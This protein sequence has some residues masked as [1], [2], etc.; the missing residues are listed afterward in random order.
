MNYISRK[1]TPIVQ[2]G[3]NSTTTMELTLPEK[4]EAIFTYIAKNNDNFLKQAKWNL[5]LSRDITRNSLD[6][7]ELT[8]DVIFSICTKLDTSIGIEKYYKILDASL[9]YNFVT[10]AIYTNATSKTAPFLYH[11]LTIKS[12]ISFA[13]NKHFHKLTI[14]ER[15]DTQDP[16][17]DHIWEYL[18]SER[19]KER[20]GYQ[21][22]YYVDIFK[23]Y[24][25]EPK[26][27]YTT[28]S[29]KYNIPRPTLA[30]NIMTLKRAIRED[31]NI[32]FKHE[33]I[34]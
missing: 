29:K 12:R 14:E 20:F 8:S 32:N 33:K 6:P 30:A 34:T 5:Q 4:K 22:K 9:L 2:F 13:D 17:V 24:L 27:S 1:Y 23:E 7:L 31:I 25:E 11:K 3:K 10:Q 21:W 16:V 28:L 15:D 18:N 26:C 19:I